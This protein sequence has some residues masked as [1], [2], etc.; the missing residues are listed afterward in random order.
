MKNILSYVSALS[1][2]IGLTLSH[3]LQLDRRQ[4]RERFLRNS[5]N[6][7]KKTAIFFLL[8]PRAIVS[9]MRPNP[10]CNDEPGATK[11]WS[12]LLRCEAIIIILE[13]VRSL[14]KEISL[15]QRNKIKCQTIQNIFT[16]I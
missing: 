1:V 8:S 13:A 2:K 3:N 7:K 16:L 15:L 11:L 4:Y 5:H 14:G 10:L 6:A 12:S 9:I